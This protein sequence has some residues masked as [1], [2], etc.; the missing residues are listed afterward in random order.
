VDAGPLVALLNEKDPAHAKCADV[1]RGMRLPMISSWVVLAE[2][3]WLLRSTKG[4]I[5][6][7]LQLLDG[8]VVEC[9]ELDAAAPSWM[10][11][12]LQKY[13]N[14]S[15]QLADAT[16]LYLAERE[17]IDSIFTLDRRDFSIYRTRKKRR[18]VLLP[19]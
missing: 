2:A 7:L 11:T 9:P 10:T 4:G 18:F 8:R 12:C 14:L 1:A 16:L 5:A 19:E 6:G 13:A 3:A 17:E 15:P